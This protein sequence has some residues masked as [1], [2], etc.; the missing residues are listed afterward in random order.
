MEVQ[1]NSVSPVLV[2]NKVFDQPQ[3]PTNPIIETTGV[4]IYA[5]KF[6][7]I[8]EV[9]MPD[10]VRQALNLDFGE[11]GNNLT[12]QLQQKVQQFPD[13]PWYVDSIDGVLYIHNK[14]LQEPSRYN[15]NY[16]FENGEVVDVSFETQYITHS[17]RG[18]AS[19]G[20]GMD[21]DL[22]EDDYIDLDLDV[23]K[24]KIAED[25]LE[26]LDNGNWNEDRIVN[27]Y[28]SGKLSENE[29]NV[30]NQKIKSRTS[31]Q[32]NNYQT[33]LSEA[34]WERIKLI[35]SIRKNEENRKIQASTDSAYKHYQM[36]NGQLFNSAQA[37]EDA[38]NET[39]A[40]KD[41]T[42]NVE[43]F[44]MRTYGGDIETVRQIQ[45]EI[46]KAAK[47][48]Y[49]DDLLKRRYS[50]LYYGF[51]SIASHGTGYTGAEVEGYQ[52]FDVSLGAF[53]KYE[54]QARTEVYAEKAVKAYVDGNPN[55]RRISPT[56]QY[57]RNGKPYVTVFGKR[58]MD[59][60]ISGY[61][62][63]SAYY[64]RKYGPGLDI[65]MINRVIAAANRTRLVT[66]RKLVAKL[67]VVGNPS[68]ATSQVVTI[69]GVGKKWSGKW[70]IKSCT[71]NMESQSGYTTQMELSRH[72]G[73]NGF[74]TVS[75]RGGHE[76]NNEDLNNDPSTTDNRVPVNNINLTQAEAYYYNVASNEDKR[77]LIMLKLSGEQDV[78]V[79]SGTVTNK[80]NSKMTLTL[81]KKPTQEQIKKYG[82]PASAFVEQHGNPQRR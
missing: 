49:L 1:D 39:L 27:D 41:L 34:G 65:D 63:L 37:T 45:S 81:K 59:V 50:D 47:N 70:Y 82:R 32:G 51:N 44:L 21:K 29:L 36:A 19:L 17:V 38:I 20:V 28:E 61:R 33:A 66:E 68:L 5:N 30:L 62:L 78:V 4:V 7:E 69:T 25:Y 73:I 54:D 75:T 10:W 23:S 26:D 16:Q 64:T 3:E 42:G 77:N 9:P 57:D 74:G 53:S 2:S 18:S 40:T 15:Y 12:I 31:P 35:N 60:V 14:K 76:V 13:G 55:F 67:T 80:G 71:H 11:V 56:I 8:G 46:D 6:A 72:K 79:Q 43:E 24:K 48:G 52:T 22:G 58:Q